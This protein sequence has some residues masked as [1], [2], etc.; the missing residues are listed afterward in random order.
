LAVKGFITGGTNY[1]TRTVNLNMSSQTSFAAASFVFPNGGTF[2]TGEVSVSGTNDV[3]FQGLPATSAGYTFLEDYNGAGLQIGTGG[4]AKPIIFNINRT[5]KMRLDASGNLGLNTTTFG[6]SK[7]QV[8]GSA[9]IGYSTSTAAPANG[10]VVSG[11]TLIGTTTDNA[12]KFQV[13]Q[14]GNNVASFTGTQY[15]NVRIVSSSSVYD[16]QIEFVT[17]SASAMTWS[18][19][20]RDDGLGG[21]TVGSLWL[22]NSA[23]SSAA[24]WISPSTNAA[25]FASSVTATNYITGGVANTASFAATGYSL[26]GANAQSLLD[27]A[28]TWNTTG[29]PTA[30]KLNITNTA[31]GST[32]NLMD[33][34]VGGVSKFKVDKAGF[35]TS[36]NTFNTQTAS[37]TLAL[38][39]ASKIIEMNASSAATITVPLNSSVAFPIGTE[40]AIFNYSNQ[41]TTIAGASGVTIRSYA[42]SLILYS[43]YTG[44]TLIKRG[45][46]EWYLIGN[47]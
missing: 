21:V 13:S 4:T 35:L 36:Y 2:L 37:Y 32:S 34:Q 17:S 1:P 10:L 45:T 15:A 26:T 33:L 43:Q 18:L 31:S 42:G 23:T 22:Y 25:T 12:N 30:I 14:T 8:F 40:I 39:D 28:G 7:F 19:G 44:A 47:I 9:A 11:N 38:T 29:N 24:L 27:L 20:K 5:E 6:A 3:F 41:T 16:A 46:D